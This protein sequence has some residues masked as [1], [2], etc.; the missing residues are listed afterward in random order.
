MKILLSSESYWP[1]FDGG[2]VFERRLAH[3]LVKAGHEVAILAPGKSWRSYIEHDDKT[4]IYRTASVRLPLNKSYKVSYYARSAVH[5]VLN[6]FQPDIIHIHTYALTG[7]SLSKAARRRGIPMVATNHLM[8]ENVLMSLPKILANA[9]WVD[10]LF[11]KKIVGF[12]E[13]F[14]VVTSPTAS[15]TA[16]LSE[17]GLTRPLEAVS[18]GIDTDYYSPSLSAPLPDVLKKSGFRKGDKYILYVGRVNAEKRLDVL[19]DAFSI[20]VKDLKDI[21]LVI[22]GSG[23]RVEVLKAQ[24]AKLGL[25][26]KVIFTGFVSDDDKRLLYQNATVFSITSPAELQS[27]VTLEALACG[28]PV[29]AVDVVALR[30]LCHDKKNGYLV[31]EGNINKLAES[32]KKVISLPARAKR[33]GEY[34][35]D[36]VCSHHSEE[37]TLRAFEEVYNRALGDIN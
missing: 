3:Q 31:P 2:A 6:E 21:H 10:R 30:E 5:R 34:S 29:V 19:V 17:H 37:A 9:R 14:S 28:L 22:A 36:F 15:A 35:R 24:A 7:L 8:P 23:N 11:W 12:H 16:L 33:F 1:N 20:V 27:I 26:D 32:I 4:I 25:V 18:N 13:R